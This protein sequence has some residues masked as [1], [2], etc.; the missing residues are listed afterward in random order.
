[1]IRE[2]LRSYWS[3]IA[4]LSIGV[5][6]FFAYPGGYAS[7]SHH[8]LHGLCAQTPSH[9]FLIGDKP[10][11]F[12]AR[13]TGIYGGLLV[14]MVTI[15][16]RGKMFRYGTPPWTV[17]VTLAICVLSMAIDGANSLFDDLNLWHP[18]PPA[19]IVRVVTGFGTG[20]SLAVALSWLAASSMWNL[21]RPEPGIHSI[22]DL[23]LPVLLLVPYVA[24]IEWAPAPL[25]LPLSLALVVSA[26]ITVS[27][28]M[29]VIVLMAFRID[30]RIRTPRH[31]HL[32]VTVA[33]ILGLTVMLVLAGARFWIEST[34]GISN[35]LM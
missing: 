11:P 24:L 3:W 25:H 22:R 20:I 32:P 21:S 5:V 19:N 26:W 23:L 31:L 12:D 16:I 14:S 33:A 30:D 7:T 27:M 15:A 28:L 10:L 34:F 17:I 18:Y 1:M 2:T 29:L 6:M 9:T 4:I 13:M 8:L 35:A